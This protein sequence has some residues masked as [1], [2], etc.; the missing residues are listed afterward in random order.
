MM[1]MTTGKTFRQVVDEI[2]QPMRDLGWELTAGEVD[3]AR[4]RAFFKHA[5]GRAVSLTLD[6]HNRRWKWHGL[7][8]DGAHPADH[9]MP[10]SIKDT[11]TVGVG[12]GRSTDALLAAF[13]KR[14]LPGY[15]HWWERMTARIAQ[16][17][18]HSAH[19]TAALDQYAAELGKGTHLSGTGNLVVTG[20]SHQVE[21]FGQGFKLSTGEL[22][23]AEM[24]V[25]V[26]ALAEVLRAR[27]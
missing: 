18:Q 1:G 12:D 11:R 14:L 19:I 10:P 9:N 27:G 8:P 2:V 24:T 5:D 16:R 17:A 26:Q 23:A 21:P 15:T 13:E 25:L 6:T 7:T 3:L 4:G 20:T 22:S